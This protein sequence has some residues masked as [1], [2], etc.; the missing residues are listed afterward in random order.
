MNDYA[1]A[2]QSLVLKTL[3]LHP[4]PTKYQGNGGK[5][6][7]LY[8][9]I[10]LTFANPSFKWRDL[11]RW[12]M[13]HIVDYQNKLLYSQDHPGCLMTRSAQTLTIETNGID[14][15]SGDF[16]VQFSYYQLWKVKTYGQQNWGW[17]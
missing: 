12:V 14:A 11:G 2:N 15:I 9:S 3:T 4:E 13:F 16:K 1:T 5:C 17:N 8:V 6:C 7:T 10:R